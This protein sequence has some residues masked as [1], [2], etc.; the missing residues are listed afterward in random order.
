MRRLSLFLAGLALA[1]ALPAV[2]QA[3]QVHVRGKIAGL[4]GDTLAVATR[5]GPVANIKLAPDWGVVIMKHVDV[6]AIQP[7][8]FIGTTN[9]ERPEGG[10]RSLEV[11]VF[12]PG[13]KMGEG[14]YPWDLQPGSMMTNGT[15][16]KVV[17][18]AN[19]RDLEVAYAGGVRHILVPPG[20]P[21]VT[22]FPGARSDVKA[23]IGVVV[24]AG[25][26]PNGDLATNRILIGEH[27][28]APP[29]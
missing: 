7:G 8:S 1:L 23:G 24:F 26:L 10:G 6:A 18:S 12:P 2:A 21:V 29:M 19:G 14:H 13:V 20:V 3:P 4:A 25:K 27:G 5:E 28:E 9:I 16:G 11:H 17:A 15:V 22:T